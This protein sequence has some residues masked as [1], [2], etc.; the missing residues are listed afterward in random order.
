MMQYANIIDG[1]HIPKSNIDYDPENPYK[2]VKE[3]VLVPVLVEAV[4]GLMAEL[5]EVKAELKALKGQ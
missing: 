2:A 5:D 1:V 3:E 4:K